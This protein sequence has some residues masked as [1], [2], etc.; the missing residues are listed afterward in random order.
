MCWLRLKPVKVHQPGFATTLLIPTIISI[1]KK[2]KLDNT[3]I[4]YPYCF[5]PDESLDPLLGS[6]RT[7]LQQD[8]TQQPQVAATPPRSRLS[9]PERQRSASERPTQ[10]QVPPVSAAHNLSLGCPTPTAAEKKEDAASTD[11]FQVRE[12]ALE[13]GV[14]WDREFFSEYFRVSEHPGGFKARFVS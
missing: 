3:V 13:C 9:R 2:L 6:P 11:D 5:R 8:K 7:S 4:R 12:S 14:H 1:T 10:R